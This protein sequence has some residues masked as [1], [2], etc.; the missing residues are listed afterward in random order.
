MSAVLRERFA[1]YLDL[2]RWNRPAGWL[3]LLWPTLA[4]LWVAAHGFPGW[5]LVAVFTLVGAPLG[6]IAFLLYLMALYLAG[7]L[8]ANQIGRLLPGGSDGGRMLPLLAGLGVVFVLVN[9]PVVGG[10]FRLVAVIIGLG[11]LLLWIRDR[12]QA[13][14]A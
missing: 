3:L 9:L 1:R 4:A 5:H 11:L 6:I 2:I 12:W 10:V 8:T 14:S 13:R 7:I